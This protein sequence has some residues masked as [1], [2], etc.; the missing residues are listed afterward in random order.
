MDTQGTLAF[1]SAELSDTFQM[2]YFGNIPENDDVP[3]LPV[4]IR[5]EPIHDIEAVFWLLCWL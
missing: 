3:V 2:S 1:M 5:H 4:L